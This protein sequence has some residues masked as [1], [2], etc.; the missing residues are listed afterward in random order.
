ML[1]DPWGARFVAGPS[2]RTGRPCQYLA[3][4][5]DPVER[6]DGAFVNPSFYETPHLDPGGYV[7]WIEDSSWWQAFADANGKVSFRLLGTA[8]FWL[9]MERDALAR[10]YAAEDA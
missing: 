9:K 2:I 1:V 5:C 8:T 7:S 10:K 3:E 6:T 4:V